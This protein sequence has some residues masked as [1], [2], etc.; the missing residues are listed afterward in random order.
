MSLRRGI[1]RLIRDAAEL[2]PTSALTAEPIGP[3]CMDPDRIPCIN[4]FHHRDSY[5][6]E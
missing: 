2:A 6:R 1:L 3:A 4:W 5:R